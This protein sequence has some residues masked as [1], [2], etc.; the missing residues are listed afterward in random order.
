LEPFEHNGYLVER[1][2]LLDVGFEVLRTVGCFG[3]RAQLKF[4]TNAE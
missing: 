1:Q 2:E 4:T 3:R